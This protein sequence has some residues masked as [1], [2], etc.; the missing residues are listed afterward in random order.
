MRRPHRWRAISARQPAAGQRHL[1][2][3]RP[4]CFKHCRRA[5]HRRA[6]L[7]PVCRGTHPRAAS[8]PGR[9]S[10]P[11][12][13]MD[14]RL[15]PAL[16]NMFETVSAT[17]AAGQLPG[18]TVN[19]FEIQLALDAVDLVR[20]QLAS[21]P[22]TYH[23]LPWRTTGPRPLP[24]PVPLLAQLQRLRLQPPL[25]PWFSGAYAAALSAASRHRTDRRG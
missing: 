16:Q 23:S 8:T 24:S 1:Q 17:M 15:L 18:G 14:E 20:T 3:S 10:P 9:H 22:C 4:E 13:A 25:P 21:R 12:R 6:P 5:E 11:A 19:T 7:A 2:N